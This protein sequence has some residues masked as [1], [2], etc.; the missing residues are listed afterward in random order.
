MGNRRRQYSG[1]TEER[2]KIQKR[3]C[4]C[5]VVRYEWEKVLIIDCC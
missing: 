1:D 2:K 3:E 5:V 4:I